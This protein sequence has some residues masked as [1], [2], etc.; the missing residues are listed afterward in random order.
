MTVSM[1]FVFFLIAGVAHGRLTLFIVTVGRTGSTILMNVINSIDGFCIRG[2]NN[3]I[4]SSIQRA[5]ADA[6]YGNRMGRIDA[7]WHVAWDG[8]ENIDVLSFGKTLVSAF[9]QHVLRCPLDATAIG[10]KEIRYEQMSRTRQLLDFMLDE[11]FFSNPRIIFNIRSNVTSVINSRKRVG[12]S[13]GGGDETRL[14]TLFESFK[15]IARVRW[16]RCCVV[17]YDD[18]SARPEA[19]MRLF[20][21]LG[22]PFDLQRVTNI[23]SHHLSH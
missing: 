15:E 20:D 19:F 5:V 22:Q 17:D 3:G 10:F 23:M 11:R 14:R 9:E 16:K 12:W 6:D 4:L 18:Y 1:V 2:E 21:F 7:S 8:A 13:V